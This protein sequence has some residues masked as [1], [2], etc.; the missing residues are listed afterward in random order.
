MTVRVP[1]FKIILFIGNVTKLARQCVTPRK[2]VLLEGM[3]YG[4]KVKISENF[5]Y[6]VYKSLMLTNLEKAKP[7]Y[8]LFSPYPEMH[9][10]L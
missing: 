1:R 7:F 8:T 10:S 5:L 3:L 2:D 6:S 9:F 4:N